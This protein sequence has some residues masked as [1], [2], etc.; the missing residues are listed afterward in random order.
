MGVFGNNALFYTPLV[1]ADAGLLIPFAYGPVRCEFTG[2]SF[3]AGTLII[4]VQH[5][6]EDMP[7]GDGTNLVREIE[8]LNLEG[9]LF[10]QTRTVPLGSTWPHD[11][12]KVPR[13]TVIGIKPKHS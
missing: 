1:G 11:S 5:P 2:P 4:S 13:P 8:C 3:V 7:I 9:G 12:T 10:A 6:G